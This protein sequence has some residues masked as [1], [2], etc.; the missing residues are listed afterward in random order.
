MTLWTWIAT[1]TPQDCEER[2]GATDRPLRRLLLCGRG[3]CGGHSINTPRPECGANGCSKATNIN[4]K[5]KNKV[6]KLKPA[7][8]RRSSSS[9][10]TK[11]HS[12]EDGDAPRRSATSSLSQSSIQIRWPGS[13]SVPQTFTN[14]WSPTIQLLHLRWYIRQRQWMKRRGGEGGGGGTGGRANG[15]SLGWGPY[16]S[17]ASTTSTS[18]SSGL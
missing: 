13:G 2:P 16:R 5:L 7:R 17:V 10:S 8:G 14:H 12:E 6:L 4:N 15:K 18:N 3:S 9:N 11:K 1:Q